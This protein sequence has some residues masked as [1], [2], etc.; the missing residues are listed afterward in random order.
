MNGWEDLLIGLRQSVERLEEA[1]KH[2]KGAAIQTQANTT[3]ILELREHLQTANQA[4]QKADKVLADIIPV[5]EVVEGEY[6]TPTK[7]ALLDEVMRTAIH[8]SGYIVK[9]RQSLG[10]P[11][12]MAKL[13]REARGANEGFRQLVREAKVALPYNSK[14]W[15]D[16]LAEIE[17]TMTK[18]DEIEQT[19][20]PNVEV[21]VVPR[22]EKKLAN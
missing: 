2:M 10:N 6:L 19:V 17:K 20:N 11:V 16:V 1:A 4:F 18:I 9:L 13:V 12:L 3:K 8:A 14:T 22:D 15:D 7:Q 5:Q 21:V